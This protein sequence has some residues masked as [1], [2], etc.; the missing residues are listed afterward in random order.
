MTSE[1]SD[2]A[3]IVELLAAS[4]AL[5][6]LAA[7][8]IEDGWRYRISNALVMA[9]VAC[10]AAY[11]GGHGSWA[12]LGWSLAAGTGVLLVGM[13]PFAFGIFGGGDTKLMAAMALWTQFAGLP[14]FLVVMSA[15]GG[16]L[17]V[18]WLI[19]R[20]LRGAGEPAGDNA[21]MASASAPQTEE[22]APGS[23][24]GLTRLPYGIAIAL[25]GVDFFLFGPHSPLIGRL[26][27]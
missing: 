3:A 12:Y 15:C 14:R 21:A 5:L 6:C 17:G 19:R 16:V 7:A 24:A 13:V 25:A 27:F 26:P 8:A 20:R 1:P 11:A 23:L 2:L 4:G 10:Y 22:S 9:L 18:I